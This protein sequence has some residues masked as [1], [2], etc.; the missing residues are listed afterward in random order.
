MSKCD[1]AQNAFNGDLRLTKHEQ[2][3]GFASELHQLLLQQQTRAACLETSPAAT[4]AA[5]V[6]GEEPDRQS[7]RRASDH[8][9][10][11]RDRFRQDHADT[12][13]PLQVDHSEER[14]EH[15]SMHHPAEKVECEKSQKSLVVTTSIT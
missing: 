12:S 8:H 15:R 11:R 5:R 9:S 7:G 14:E 6:L 3:Q 10:D 1:R 4:E 13:V 2:I